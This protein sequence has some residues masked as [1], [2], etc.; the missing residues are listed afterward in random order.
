MAEATL[1]TLRRTRFLPTSAVF[2]PFPFPDSDNT[3]RRSNTPA[4]VCPDARFAFGSVWVSGGVVA[5]ISRRDDS[6]ATDDIDRAAPEP[7]LCLPVRQRLHHLLYRH[8]TGDWNHLEP[9]D[10]YCNDRA[11]RVGAKVLTWFALTELSH[12][13]VSH[14]LPGHSD[15]P[16]HLSQRKTP[17]KIETLWIITNAERHRTEILLP[18]EYDYA[19]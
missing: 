16:E 6:V 5:I 11:L 12:A 14:G 4:F 7:R 19:D 3:Y 17:T 8:L 10:A 15:R 13:S 2:T 9:E 1:A 18:S